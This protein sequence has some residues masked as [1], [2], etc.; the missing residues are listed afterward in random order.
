MAC[1]LIETGGMAHARKNAFCGHIQPHVPMRAVSREARKKIGNDCFSVLEGSGAPPADFVH[2]HKRAEFGG[3][4]PQNLASKSAYYAMLSQRYCVRSSLTC[5][6]RHSRGVDMLREANSGRRPASPPIR[7]LSA[8]LSRLP[9]F[10]LKSPRS[11]SPMAAKTMVAGC[12]PTQ[13]SRAYARMPGLHQGWSTTFDSMGSCVAEEKGPRDTVTIARETKGKIDEMREAVERAKKESEAAKR[14]ETLAYK[15]QASSEMADAAARNMKNRQELEAQARHERDMR[16]AF[17]D[18]QQKL[19]A[20]EALA[21]QHRNEETAKYKAGLRE[22]AARDLQ[23]RRAAVA[24][25]REDTFSRLEAA[26]HKRRAHVG[27]RRSE[28][29]SPEW[30]QQ[31]F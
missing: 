23:A 28:V 18:E 11:S 24:K 3:K 26:A 20:K 31:T 27:M 5:T 19:A 8:D 29:L 12:H 15:Q 30:R 1:G 14:A 9:T 13:G 17:Q 4:L 21:V 22:Q 2:F 10:S 6:E 7:S 16:A 25:A